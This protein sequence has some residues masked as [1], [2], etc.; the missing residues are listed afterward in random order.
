MLYRRHIVMHALHIPSQRAGE[1]TDAGFAHVLE[2]FDPLPALGADDRKQLRQRAE[3]KFGL[4]A[5]P[6]AC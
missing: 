6:G 1:G 5:V 3:G 2:T 4:E